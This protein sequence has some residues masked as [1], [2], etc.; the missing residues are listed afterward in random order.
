MKPNMGS[1]DRTIRILAAVGIIAL[2][3]ANVITGTI[4]LLALAF[5]AIFLLTGFVS[6]CPLY[7]PFK[8]STRKK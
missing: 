1:L 8:F 3:F 2:Y 7:A 5:A 4:G 6:F